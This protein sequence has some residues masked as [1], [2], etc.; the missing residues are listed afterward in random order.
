M[1]EV[2]PFSL[3]DSVSTKTMTVFTTT[4][5]PYLRSQHCTAFRKAICQCTSSPCQTNPINLVGG[6]SNYTGDM[7]NYG[8]GMGKALR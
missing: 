2:K 1:L 5:T 4:G 8:R 6:R 7:A 3:M